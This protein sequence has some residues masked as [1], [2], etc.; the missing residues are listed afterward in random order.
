MNRTYYTREY[1]SDF[2]IT[3]YVTDEM[4]WEY[5]VGGQSAPVRLDTARLATDDE[6][7]DFERR[8]RGRQERVAAMKEAERQEAERLEPIYGFDPRKIGLRPRGFWEENGELVI[9]AR[10]GGGNDVDFYAAKHGSFVGSECDEFD[11]TYRYYR[12]APL[13]KAARENGDG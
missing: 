4:K 9:E 11:C 8:E 5:M 7:V 1:K 13:E 3:F 12:Y 2:Q 6:V 10:D